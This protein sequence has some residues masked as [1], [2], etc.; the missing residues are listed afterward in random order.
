MARIVPAWRHWHREGDLPHDSGVESPFFYHPRML[1]Y[2]FGPRHPLKPERLRRAVELIGQWGIAPNDPGEGRL[3][4]VLRVHDPLFVETVEG[5]SRGAFVNESVRRL[6]GFGTIDNPV[7]AGM[8]EASL[9]YVAGSVRAAEAVRDG[10]RLAFGLAGGLHHAHRSRASGFCVFNDAAIA[11]SVLRERFSRVAYIDIDVHHGDGVQFLF[12]E[13]PQVLTCSIHESPASLFPGTGR[14]D[15]V[16]PAGTAVNVPLAA[17]TTGDVWL[18]AFEH[19]ILEPITRFEPEAV[20]LQMGTDAHVDDPLGHLR[21]SAQEWLR[22]VVLVRE[23]GLPIAA[24][25]GGG[26]N[27]DNVPRMWGAACVALAGGVVPDTL[28]EDLAET[29]GIAGT[30]DTELPEPRNRG[31]EEAEAAVEVLCRTLSW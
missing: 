9:A 7:F 4:D 17:G 25:G 12:E 23:L 5:L 19:G 18:W 29:W 21:V 24:L 2:D 31:R 27:L 6:T 15:D 13:D 14:A 30:F 10:A 11:L 16:G 28:P 22:A 26:Y 8:F 1:A 20:V 3:E